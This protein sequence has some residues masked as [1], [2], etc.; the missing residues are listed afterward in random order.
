MGR[1]HQATI[2]PKY[3]CDHDGDGSQSGHAIFNLTK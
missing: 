1:F 2:D 3:F